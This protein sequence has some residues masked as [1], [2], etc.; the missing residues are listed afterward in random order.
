[1][2]KRYGVYLIQEKLFKTLQNQSYH[3]QFEGE[4]LS[5]EMED[6]VYG[7]LRKRWDWFLKDSYIED[8]IFQALMKN[9]FV[10]EFD[11]ESESTKNGI[12]YVRLIPNTIT[13]VILNPPDFKSF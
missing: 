9:I 2:N 3:Y 6:S 7:A 8:P 10:F 11:V 1:M 4:Y 5:H 12:T 13:R